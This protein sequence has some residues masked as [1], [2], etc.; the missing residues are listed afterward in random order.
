[1]LLR[2]L[3]HLRSPAGRGGRL[4]IM[5]FHRVLDQP[6]ALFPDEPDR[7]RFS[8]ILQWVARW[9]QVLPLDRAVTALQRGALPARAM[10]ITFDDGYA[11]NA[12]NAAPLL[13]Q[14]GMCA[15]FF[16]ATSF[17]DGGRM[18]NDTVI[19]SI[20]HSRAA[21]LDL[22]QLGLDA[23][24]LPLGTLAQ[25]R[26]AVGMALRALKHLPPAQRAEKSAALQALCG[27]AALPDDMMMRSDQV[28]GLV[29]AGMQV[30]AHTLTHPILCSTDD[31][32]ARHEITGSKRHLEHLLGQPVT[33]FAY[34][35]GKPDKD[36][37]RRHVDMV[38]DAGFSAAVSTAPGAADGHADL[39]QLPR[40]TPWDQT[41]GRFGVRLA[42]NLHR[43]GQRC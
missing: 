22:R 29:H 40:F 8:Q 26:T 38:R 36:Y 30:G 4:S 20:R 31:A 11:D 32:Q 42:H 41:A 21:T 14:H 43:D 1:M 28:Q 25:K 12:L 16:I 9:Y 19:E 35:N 23:D 39:L 10:C 27:T 37:D 34:P 13:Q 18:W 17:L 7:Q 3:T 33:L 5:I 15:T 6:D 2:A 24:P